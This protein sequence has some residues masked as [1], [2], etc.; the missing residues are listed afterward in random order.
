LSDKQD[1]TP[2]KLGAGT[3]QLRLDQFNN[4]WYQPGRNRLIQLIWYYV[5]HTVF[6]S[7]WLPFASIKVRLLRMFGA[8]VGK[9]VVIKPKV[10]IKYP[11]KLCIGDHCWIGEKVWI[12]NL[13][14]VKLGNHVCLSQGAML[15]CGS[16]NYK[17]RRFGL[18][19]G[20]IHLEDGVWIG[21]KA[22]VCPGVTAAS[23]SI[24]AVSSVATKD[25]EAYTI[26]QGNPAKAKR[27]RMIDGE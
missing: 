15:L 18:I 4:H 12:D 9:G 17:K 7:Y 14:E 25:L 27:K 26:Y 10:N 3:Q 13:A 5:N 2:T 19:L 21:A 20:D 24:L 6:N 22:V 8:E 11:W 23:H 1:I 16:H